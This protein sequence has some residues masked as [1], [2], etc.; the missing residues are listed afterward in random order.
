MHMAHS[1]LENDD[2][3][4]VQESVDVP[5]LEQTTDGNGQC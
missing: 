1:L 4:A 3:I 5:E 2:R